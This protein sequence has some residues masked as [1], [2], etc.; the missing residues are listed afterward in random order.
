MKNERQQRGMTAH[1]QRIPGFRAGR[2]WV[3]VSKAIR[4]VAVNERVI[5]EPLHGP[6]PGPGVAEG[7][8]CWQQVRVL[9]MEFVFERA[10]GALAADSACQPAPDA[11]IGYPVGEVG[12]VLVPDPGRQRIDDEQVQFVEVDRC[13]TFRSAAGS[14]SPSARA[15]RCRDDA[16]GCP[17]PVTSGAGSRR[18]GRRVF[19]CRSAGASCRR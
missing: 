13:R 1:G 5:G 3:A 19:A 18:S 10:E 2:V 15:G 17:L 8:P 6:A 14:R 12:H 4:R 11:L 7:T 16:V 9:L